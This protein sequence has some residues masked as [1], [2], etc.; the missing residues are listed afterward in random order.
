[1]KSN[2]RRQRIRETF[3]FIAWPA[4]RTLGFAGLLAYFD[5]STL[6][7]WWVSG[8]ALIYA[9]LALNGVIRLENRFPETD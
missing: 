1:M 7:L 8:S 2:L 6:A 3:L 9:L 4:A 5:Y